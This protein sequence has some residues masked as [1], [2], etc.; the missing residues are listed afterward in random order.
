MRARPRM[1]PAT[2]PCPAGPLESHP[3]ALWIPA[4]STPG[5]LLPDCS[6][7]PA[8]PPS[9]QRQKG[10]PDLKRLVGREGYAVTACHLLTWTAE[11]LRACLPAQE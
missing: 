11:I 10:S 7:P 8:A 9:P 1:V 4:R 3:G 6:T 2:P 5:P